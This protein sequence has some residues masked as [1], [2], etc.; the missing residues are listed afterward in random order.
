M[1]KS[2]I[3]KIKEMFSPL[4]KDN[5]VKYGTNII[6]ALLKKYLRV[7]NRV[8]DFSLIYGGNNE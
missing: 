8:S 3:K 5:R 6:T 7:V 2:E 4:F 1:E